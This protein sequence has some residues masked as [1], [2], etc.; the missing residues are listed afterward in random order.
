MA[1]G[2]NRQESKV[3][4]RHFCPFFETA[5]PLLSRSRAPRQTSEKGE[6][7]PENYY[8]DSGM[9]SIIIVDRRQ[10]AQTPL[11]KCSIDQGNHPTGQEIPNSRSSRLL[12]IDPGL[13]TRPSSS[14]RSSVPIFSSGPHPQLVLP[15]RF[16]RRL[17]CWHRTP[18]TPSNMPTPDMTTAT[19]PLDVSAPSRSVLPPRG[20]S[21]QH[22]QQRST[23][24]GASE[25]IDYES[26]PT[27][28]GWGV[29]M[30][31]GAMV[32]VSNSALEAGL[33]ETC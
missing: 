19:G 8:R 23:P 33:N 18:R 20:A 22:Q 25:D 1:H 15:L 5:S 32:G 2:Q 3:T 27:G 16:L 30:L 4:N 24:D 14:D 13:Q 6:M 12:E 9:T 11:G 28:A 31:A 26:L 17:R 21:E 10:L 29:H 7:R